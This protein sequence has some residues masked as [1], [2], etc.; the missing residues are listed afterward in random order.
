MVLVS[1]G[2]PAM[3]CPVVPIKGHDTGGSGMSCVSGKSGGK[4]GGT[5]ESGEALVQNAPGGGGP[6]SR[7]ATLKGCLEVHTLGSG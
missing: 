3:A 4:S 2:G 5:R 1:M 7:A 6:L